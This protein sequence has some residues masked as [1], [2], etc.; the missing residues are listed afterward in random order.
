M[1]KTESVWFGFEKN[2]QQTSN[3]CIYWTVRIHYQGSAIKDIATLHSQTVINHPKRQK[4]TFQYGYPH[5]IPMPNPRL[6]NLSNLLQKEESAHRHT[7]S[8][9]IPQYWNECLS[10]KFMYAPWSSSI[11]NMKMSEAKHSKALWNIKH[12]SPS[13]T[14]IHCSPQTTGNGTCG[15]S[16]S[17]RPAPE[18]RA[19][20]YIRLTSTV[21]IFMLLTFIF[22]LLLMCFSSV[23]Q[24]FSFTSPY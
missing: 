22:N 18:R 15:V 5:F 8:S 7:L 14:S 11:L 24:F 9:V 19:R 6:S 21:P 20:L 10:Y 13:Q 12:I 4:H 17:S 23:L 1:T 2:Q 3:L 16:T